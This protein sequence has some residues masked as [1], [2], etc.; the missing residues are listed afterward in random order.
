MRVREILR[1]DDPGFANTYWD[2]D[3]PY[4]LQPGMGL[5]GDKLNDFKFL[6]GGAVF[7]DTTRELNRYGIYGALWVMLPDADPP[8]TL[9]T[10]VFPP[11]QG[12][13]GGPSAGPIMNLAGE[14]I[15]AFV[16]PLAVRPGTLLEVSD[17]FS[18][19]AQLAPTLPAK[20]D[21]SVSGPK[22]FSRTFG[23]R[24]NAIGYFYD[25][26]EDF[27]VTTPGIYHVSVTATFDMP[28]S[29][30]PM[31]RPYPTGTVLGAI[32]NGFDI[33]VVPPDGPAL[34]TS[35]PAWAVVRGVVEV[36]LL[37]EAPD[38]SSSGTIHYTMAMPGFLLESG[39]SELT[40]GYGMLAYD[41]LKLNLTF[42][43]LDVRFS[44]TDLDGQDRGLVDTVWV[45]VLLETEDGDFY[46]RQFTLQG[47]DL[48]A[49][50]F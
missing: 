20:V 1:D 42:P 29:A 46:G 8:L 34:A 39:T 10:R 3:E 31:S 24:A 6:F 19:S 37:V 50:T 15:D 12:A 44:R 26:G 17:T 30:G 2:F 32:E 16:V 40:N 43:N 38:G 7:R 36:P 14:E 22:G 35:H 21:V 13:N 48:H 27:V 18:F 9:V 49:L 33:Y 28:T 41:P 45:S 23:G 47:P 11:F 4:A 25:P 5:E